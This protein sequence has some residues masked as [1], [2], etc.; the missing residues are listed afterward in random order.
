MNKFKP[1]T[2]E[3][4]SFAEDYRRNLIS[5][6]EWVDTQ[7][8]AQ[9]LE[10]ILASYN[11]G[12][13]LWLAGN[14]GSASWA[15]HLAG[16]FLKECNIP[17]VPLTNSTILTAYS[18]DLSYEES[19]SLQ[20]KDQNPSR[21]DVLI[22]F[23]GSGNS[24]NILALVKEAIDME[25][26]VIGVSGYDGGKLALVLTVANNPRVIHIN[27]PSMHM[28]RSQDSHSMIGHIMCYYVKEILNRR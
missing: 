8:I 15:D 23:S 1:N 6:L 10:L 3:I 5:S 4:L 28:G 24:K 20:L 11:Q 13:R 21:K 25:M 14:G 26:G 22:V 19:F 27:T 16:D 9:G 18:N 7:K 2:Q 12:G 17:A